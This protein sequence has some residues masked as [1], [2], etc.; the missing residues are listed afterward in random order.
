MGLKQ[1]IGALTGRRGPSTVQ[2]F[3]AAGRCR[4]EGRFE[5]AADL[6]A[7][8]LARDPSSAV[9]HLMAA[10]LH[11]IFRRM[12]AAKTEFERVLA[13]DATHPRALLGMARIALEENDEPTAADHLRRALARYPDFPEAQALLDVIEARRFPDAAPRRPTV[14]FTAPRLRVPAES[15]E[16][17]LARHDGSLLFVQPAGPRDDALAVHVAQ[18]ARLGTAILARVGGGALTGAVVEGADDVSHVRTDG[19]LVAALTF[20]RGMPTARAAEHLEHVWTA[21]AALLARGEER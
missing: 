5:E 13:L 2:L 19:E 3:R 11:A 20:T 8:A 6:V 18:L 15:R 7:R 1:V 21:A 10:W 4:D 14:G 12:D 17:I 9:G 16:V